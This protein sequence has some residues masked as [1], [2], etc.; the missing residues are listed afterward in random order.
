[1]IRESAK[2]ARAPKRVVVAPDSE[3]DGQCDAI[4]PRRGSV[5][6]HFDPIDMKGRTDVGGEFTI[7]TDDWLLDGGPHSNV[8]ISSR[9]RLARNLPGFPFS[10][11]ANEDQ[12]EGVVG[13]IAQ[14]LESS[15]YFKGFRRFDVSRIS[16]QDRRYL[17]ESHLIST[18]FE[19]GQAHREVYVSPD[20]RT[21][22]MV[23]EEDHLRV[24]TMLPGLQLAAVHARIE[25]IDREL[26]AVLK[27]AY[28][29]QFGYLAACPTNTGTGLRVS[30]MLHLVGL[31]L[32]NQIEEALGSLGNFGLVVRGSYGEHSANTGEIFQVSNEVTLGKTEDE[33]VQVLGQVVSQIIEKEL[34]AR[35]VL[36]EHDRVRY[37]DTIQRAIGLLR[38]ARRIDSKEAVA[39]LSRIRLGLDGDYGVRLS[40]E[41][42]NRLLIE[43]QPAHLRRAT[44]TE[45]SI[46]EGDAARAEMLRGR[47]DNGG[48]GGNKN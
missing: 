21:S 38:F 9:A 32:T 44:N 35:Q 46:E 24:Q 23:N 39:L 11:R 5:T 8:V 31:V 26:E 16:G 15:E 41:E 10:P 42:L 30:V 4:R 13:K 20:G 1:V 12:L 29:S 37:E 43:V 18:E 48:N 34:R 27:F 7:K 2:A 17:R 3:T 25:E 36:L 19:K 40:H 6:D 33:L 45:G 28:L 14:A 47:F 22:I